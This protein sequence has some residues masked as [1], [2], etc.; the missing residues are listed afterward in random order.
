MSGKDAIVA[1][2]EECEIKMTAEEN[3]SA[4]YVAAPGL[5]VTNNFA[6]KGAVFL[7]SKVS[8]DASLASNIVYNKN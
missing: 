4:A 5:E 8:A 2:Y 6:G 1:L 3:P 7:N